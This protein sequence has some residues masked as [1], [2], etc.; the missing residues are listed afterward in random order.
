VPPSLLLLNSVNLV[1]LL[2]LPLLLA[3]TLAA[4]CCCRS[5]L[6]L[7]LAATLAA[8]AAR[9]CCCCLLPPSLLL[10]LLL[11]LTTTV[12]LL[13]LLLQI[14]HFHQHHN[15]HTPQLPMMI[16]GGLLL[17]LKLLRKNVSLHSVSLCN[18]NMSQAAAAAAFLSQL[19]ACSH[20]LHACS[21]LPSCCFFSRKAAAGCRR[22]F[23]KG[24]WGAGGSGE[25]SSL[26]Q[27]PNP[28]SAAAAQ[29]NACLALSLLLIVFT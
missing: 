5:L 11:L 29:P 21:S 22:S 14:Q 27:G 2:P 20:P 10:L 8:A 26:R 16:A 3:A 28:A 7:L 18:R 12:L 9:C 25:I 19:Q 6:L 15:H 24:K 13:L 23:G 4:A 17:K 1:L